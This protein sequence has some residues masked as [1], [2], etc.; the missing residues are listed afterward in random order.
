MM[1]SGVVGSVVGIATALIVIVRS[2]VWWRRAAADSVR[3]R[4]DVILFR[5]IYLVFGIIILFGAL[6]SLVYFAS[7]N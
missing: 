5:V 4:F 6:L 3:E 2:L 1:V 7:E